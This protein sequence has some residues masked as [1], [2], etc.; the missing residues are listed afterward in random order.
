MRISPVRIWK[1]SPEVI[2]LSLGKKLSLSENYKLSEVEQPVIIS[3]SDFSENS[4]DNFSDNLSKSF[5]I[6]SLKL[7]LKRVCYDVTNSNAR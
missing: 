2:K 4:G 1:L 5:D 7:P 6:F 3:F